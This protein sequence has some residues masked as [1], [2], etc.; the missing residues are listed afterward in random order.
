MGHVAVPGSLEHEEVEAFYQKAHP[1]QQIDVDDPYVVI[2]VGA[3]KTTLSRRDLRRR[4]VVAVTAGE[5]FG[6]AAP[7]AAGAL[8]ADS[9]PGVIAAALLIAAVIEGGVLA[10]FQGRVLRWWLHEFPTCDWIMATVA[11]A[12][13]AWTVGLM[14]VLYGDQFGRW[15][16]AVQIPVV[17]AGAIVMVFAIGVA[18]CYVL[19]RWSD[20]A[21]LWIWGNAVGWIAGLA[22]FAAVTS[23]LWRAGQSTMVT[24]MIGA[25]GGLVMAAVA[26]ATTGLFLVR[27]L[28]PWHLRASA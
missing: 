25:L 13:V 17:A 27:I 1:R 8:T 22:A 23:P 15:P 21:A 14:P 18:Q 2:V 26:A 16:I 3:E 9:A 10:L 5:T 6:F 4:W 28:A 20:R 12:L 24:A 11:G 19:R 7:A